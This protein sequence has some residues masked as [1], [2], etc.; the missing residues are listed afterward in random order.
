MLSEKLNLLRQQPNTT[1]TC[2]FAETVGSMPQS[3]RDA[4]IDALVTNSISF[5]ALERVLFE[6]GIQIGRD[7]LAKGRMCLM[8]A[9]SCRCGFAN[10]ETGK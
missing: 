4:L 1:K 6:E 8:N 5:R 7:S 9:Q 10:E 3:D 2:H